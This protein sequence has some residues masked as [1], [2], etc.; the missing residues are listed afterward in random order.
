M[1]TEQLDSARAL[2]QR[3]RFAGDQGRSVFGDGTF[4]S[5]GIRN[6][7]DEHGLR[8]SAE[9]TPGLYEVLEQVCHRLQIVPTNVLAFVYA[10]PEIQA[11]CYSG[12]TRDCLVTLTSGL[13]RLMSKQELA[14]VIGHELGHFLLGHG[15][16]ENT[17]DGSIEGILR[18]RSG[19]ISA[20]RVGMLACSSSEAAFRALIKTSSGLE[21]SH[22]RFD[23]S[24][25]LEQLRGAAKSSSQVFSESTHPPLTMRCRAMLW[26]EMSDEY[27]QI[28]GGRRGEPL[29]KVDKRLARELKRFVDGPARK[30]IADATEVLRLWMTVAAA[31]RDG[32]LDKKE[33]E[34][35]GEELGQETLGKVLAFL[36]GC[37]SKT[38]V[39]SVVQ[40]KA[41]EAAGALVALA[42]RE[43]PKQSAVM[44][45]RIGRVFSQDD[46][47]PFFLEFSGGVVPRF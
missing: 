46:F 12:D 22:L 15:R 29:A 20:D 19:E 25:Y 26:F 5:S 41:Q 8:L 44:A 30:R 21:A 24:A 13:I 40:G 31:V 28:S 10:S 18:Q 36:S 42:P 35:I 4:A 16:R 9:M 27:A 43:Y 23:L 45:E 33:Q 17:I 39:E 2:V 37:E 14:F 1:S 7:F 38:E 34:L 3:V 47:Q 32:M 6:Q 11:T